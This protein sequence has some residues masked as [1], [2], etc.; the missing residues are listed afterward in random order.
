[1]MMTFSDGT[2][3]YPDFF[4]LHG[5]GDRFVYDVKPSGRMNDTAATQF[6]K[7]ADVCAHIG[8]RHEVL[9]EAHPTKVRNLEWLRSARHPRYHP[10]Q[11]GFEQIRMPPWEFVTAP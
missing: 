3:H 9:H 10:A 8:W 7:T 6:E 4:A 1:M 2:R 5:N 11:S